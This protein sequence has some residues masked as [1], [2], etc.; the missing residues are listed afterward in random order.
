MS[1][2]KR[3]TLSLCG[4]LSVSLLL[5][6]LGL[7]QTTPPISTSTAVTLDRL[8]DP[9][10]LERQLRALPGDG[11]LSLA[12]GEAHRGDFRLGAGQSINGDL[13]VLK[14]DADLSGKVSG[15][16][17][18]LDGDI[19]LHKGALV[20]GDALALNGAIRERGGVIQG[21]RRALRAGSGGGETA[22]PNPAAPAAGVLAKAAGLAGVLFTLTLLG[23]GMVLFAQPQLETISDTVSHS[24]LRA[25]ATGLLAQVVVLPTL[26][27][28]VTGLVLSV[29][30]IILVPFVLL[31]IPLALSVALVAGFLAVA[32]A[33]GETRV[34]RRMAAGARVGSVNSYGYLLSGLTGIG[35]LWAA[36]VLVGW[37]PV[38][39]A[40]MFVAAVLATWLLA[41]IGFG[42]ALLSRGGV[43][44]AFSGRLVPPEAMTDEYLWATPRYGV[45]AV[46]RPPKGEK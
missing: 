29:V 9:V 8:G 1:R 19:L 12:N 43:K 22:A 41:T 36:W 28:V 39:G 46:K 37:V 13:L 38:A 21:E 6:S 31:V 11:P 44:P 23:F 5:P 14:G 16:V 10:S 3:L 42:A 20:R 15:N 25:F 40:L 24:L 35:L 2:G 26:G 33:M 34:R 17:V 30:G 27:M 32:H 7:A 18:V 45:S 4:W